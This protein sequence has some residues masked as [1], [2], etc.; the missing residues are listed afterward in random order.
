[1]IAW[2]D[3]P[4]EKTDKKIKIEGKEGKDDYMKRQMKR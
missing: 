1:M 2:R 3:E 4:I